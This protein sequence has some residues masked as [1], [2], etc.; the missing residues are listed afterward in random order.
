MFVFFSRN[1]TKF[2][3]LRMKR[4]KKKLLH[5]VKGSFIFRKKKKNIKRYYRY[6]E[7]SGW[8]KSDRRGDDVSIDRTRERQSAF[9]IDILVKKKK[10]KKKRN[11]D[12][13]NNSDRLELTLASS[14]WRGGTIKKKERMELS[15]NE[16][17][18]GTLFNYLLRFLTFL[19]E[20]LDTTLS[21]LISYF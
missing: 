15:N 11:Y 18:S 9:I 8:P 16:S 2:P 6:C 7:A 14:F 21:Y 12:R 17:V 5:M 1:G 3:Q 4:K 10:K 13:S 20:L 19:I